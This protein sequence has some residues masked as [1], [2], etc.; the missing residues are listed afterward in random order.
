MSILKIT[1][2]ALSFSHFGLT[3]SILACIAMAAFYVLSLYFWS[4][5]NRF[6]RNEPSVIRR[7][8]LSVT[9][10]CILCFTALLAAAEKHDSGHLIHHWLGLRF[11]P[12]ACL[13]AALATCILFSGPIVQYMVCEYL[14]RLRFQAYDS[15]TTPTGVKSRLSNLF[16]H[17]SAHL[18]DLCFWRNYIISPFT[19][20]FVFRGCML[21]LLVQSLTN[22]QSI[23]VA[24]LFFGL[25]HLHHIA[26]GY[27]VHGQELKHLILQHLFQFSYTYVFGV[28]SSYLFLRTGDLFSCFVSHSICNGMGFPNLRQ[29]FGDFRPAVKHCILGVYVLGLVAFFYLVP[30]LT[31]PALYDNQTYVW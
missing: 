18:K 8:F 25:A 6:N 4:K 20:E 28:Y 29:L 23:L 11:S 7:R 15:D 10:T 12:G 13:S 17:A 31:E 27:F 14:Y 21:P 3:T 19:E 9:L 16:T 30:S 24:P 1:T 26:E 5:Q 2:T 22:W